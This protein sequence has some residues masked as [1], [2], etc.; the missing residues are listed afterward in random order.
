MSYELTEIDRKQLPLLRNLY[1]DNASTN[2][3]SYVTVDTYI[4]WFE[5]DPDV[6]QIKFFCLNGDLSRG[7]FVVTVKYKLINAKLKKNR[8]KIKNRNN[9]KK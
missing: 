3:I 2:Y 4:R 9:L 8:K 5:Q 6:K 7:T 1:A